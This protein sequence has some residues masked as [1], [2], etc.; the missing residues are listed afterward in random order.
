MIQLIVVQQNSRLTQDARSDRDKGVEDLA[1]LAAVAT[2]REG[3]KHLVGFIL[4]VGRIG[5]FRAA[6]LFPPLPLS[7][8]VPSLFRY[9][10][11]GHGGDAGRGLPGDFNVSERPR[12]QHGERIS[13]SPGPA[14]NTPLQYCIEKS[15]SSS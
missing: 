13:D 4:E 6:H 3:L 9:L 15:A 11:E 2:R 14:P 1:I 5:H 10:S 8:Q 12:H 7:V